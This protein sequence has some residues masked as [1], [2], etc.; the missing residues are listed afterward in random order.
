[1]KTSFAF[2]LLLICIS[3]EVIADQWL[4]KAD[5]FEQRSAAIGFSLYGKG[6]FGTGAS[7]SDLR[8]DLWC[9][10]PVQDSWS[11]MADLPGAGRFQAFSFAIGN[12][13][14]VGE[15]IS[16]PSADE[17][18]EY[19]PLINSWA[20]KADFP[21]VRYATVSFSIGFKGF[22]ITG[23]PESGPVIK[24]VWEYDPAT[25]TWLQ[26]NDF[27]GDAR[28]WA[29]GFSINTK[30]YV[31]G[32]SDSSTTWRNDFFEYD[33]F[34]D[35]WTQKSDFPGG[36]IIRACTFVISDKG[37]VG[38]GLGG[39]GL[40]GQL[41][42]YNPLNDSWIQKTSFAGSPRCFSSTFTVN[43]VA[44]VCAGDSNVLGTGSEPAQTHWAYVPDSLDA[45]DELTFEESGLEIFP[46]PVHDFFIVHS[47]NP[48]L[49]SVYSEEGKELFKNR[50]CECV[51]K[52]NAQKWAAGIYYLKAEMN[53]KIAV[54]RLI[55]D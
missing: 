42:Q 6:Y 7:A 10:D 41:W 53:N 50:K 44:Y 51:M 39:A 18:F 32:G 8:K 55:K 22:V 15:G 33:P 37:Y 48:V 14:Y 24:E 30:G 1:M 49:F 27:V 54:H 31:G 26:K 4:R 5:F 43:N 19:D 21:G 16:V 2:V 3:N 29:F 52:L 28:C 46:N 45:I 36:P 47:R 25:D 35:Q 9:Y 11:Q 38:P 20:I 23:L 40:T 12:K 17:F 13:G 34:A